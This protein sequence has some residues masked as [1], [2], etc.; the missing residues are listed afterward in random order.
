MDREKKIRRLISM[1]K[2]FLEAGLGMIAVFVIDIAIDYIASGLR[3]ETFSPH[4]MTFI[5]LMGIVFIIASGLRGETF[6][7]HLMT[8]ILLMGIVFIV[9]H[10]ICKVMLSRFLK[11]QR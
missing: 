1:K 4:L 5:L 11:A 7:P 10:F 6:S 9:L 3:G 8:F 2:Y